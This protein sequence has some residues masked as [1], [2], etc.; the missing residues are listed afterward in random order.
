MNIL[1]ITS[2]Y[3]SLSLSLSLY[4]SI[5]LS[6]TSSNMIKLLVYTVKSQKC[7][8]LQVIKIRIKSSSFVHVVQQY[9]PTSLNQREF[10]DSIIR[11]D[12]YKSDRKKMFTNTVSFHVPSGIGTN[13]QMNRY[14]FM[15]G[16]M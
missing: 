4:L 14:F 11:R 12:T 6:V 3:L 10:R 5:Y 9:H 8:Y 2:I 7:V 16:P 15:D 1:Q 13:Y